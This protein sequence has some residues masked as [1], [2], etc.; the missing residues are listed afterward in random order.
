MKQQA[1]ALSEQWIQRYYDEDAERE[2]DR[3]KQSSRT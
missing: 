2:P 3:E 1:D